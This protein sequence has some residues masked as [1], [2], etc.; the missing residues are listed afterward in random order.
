M[1]KY[2]SKLAL[3]NTLMLNGS[4]DIDKETEKIYP[5]QNRWDYMFSYDNEVFFIEVH[6]AFTSEVSVVLKKLDWLKKWLNTNTI[7]LKRLKPKIHKQFYWIQS[8]NFAI[9]PNSPQYRAALSN[10]LLPISK[11]KI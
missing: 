3:K 1:G 4:V 11:L 8:N 10:G 6:S 2:S 5:N 7:I 9:L